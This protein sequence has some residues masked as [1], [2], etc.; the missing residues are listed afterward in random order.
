MKT[1]SNKQNISTVTATVT[2]ITFHNEESGFIVL[3]AKNK[4]EE[5]TVVGKVV[6][7]NIAEIIDCEG[8]WVKDKNY[9][10]QFHADTISVRPPTS[11]KGI[12]KYLSSGM[13]KGIGPGFAKRL[14][15]KFGDDVL[16]V[17]EKEPQRLFELVGIGKKRQQQI[18]SAWQEQKVI[19]N[20]MV[21]LQ[22]HG[23][24]C[25]RAFRIFR[26]YGNNAIDLIRKNPY[27]L[28]NDIAGIGF[29]IADNL[30]QSIGIATDS[31]LRVRAGI[32]HA[33]QQLSEQGGTCA[34]SLNLINTTKKLLNVS[35]EKV[36]EALQ[37]EVAEE[38]IIDITL[39]EEKMY[40]IG[41][42]FNA[43]KIIAT[44]LLR[45]NSHNALANCELDKNTLT[46]IQNYL[47]IEL[48]PSQIKASQTALANTVSIITGGPGVGKTTLVN[49][50]LT[51]LKRNTAKIMLA[52]P[53]GRAAKR[54]SQTT[55][56]S[57]KTIHR[58]LGFNAMEKA[59]LHNS[60]NPL[61]AE[62]VIVDEC[63]MIDTMLMASLVQAI[64]TGCKLILVGDIDQLPSVGAGAI[65]ADC[66]SSLQFSTITLTEIFR[67]AATSQIVTNAHLVNQGIMP[68]YMDKDP[69]SDFF[70][71]N[72]TEPEDICQK[73]LHMI[74]T[75][76]PQKFSLDSQKDIQVLAPTNR[77]TLGVIALN[78]QLQQA[79]NPNPNVMIEKFGR[80]FSTGDKVIQ[81]TNNYDKEVYNGDSGFILNIDTEQQ[82]LTVDYSNN[83][84]R[85]GF[86]ELDE[87]NLA[88]A[89]TIHK[90]QGSE[91]PAVVIPIAT[92]HYSL[93]QRN[94]IY[95]AITRGK[96]LVV[97]IGQKKA[98][99]MAIR[100]QEAKNRL[101]L[102]DKML[103]N[104]I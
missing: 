33:L 93:L 34:T 37:I 99:G 89:I 71:I 86:D 81:L 46:Q 12:E 27:R 23:I 50:I 35:S 44:N 41:Y 17:I 76:I 60:D 56:M 36:E 67:Q 58:M 31:I 104:I 102:L 9:G 40:A 91:Y 32:C 30:A 63:S 38:N 39:G 21:F 6:Q 78:Q 88:W 42:L 66:I 65:L 55:N 96:K 3:R 73:I 103:E 70:V 20:I 4:T 14:I 85:Y 11:T 51:I 64:P 87:I 69:N 101:T 22:S 83:I 100:N 77:G 74:T 92:Q 80:K 7:V 2:R 24:G 59:F 18:I 61:D 15:K 43:E 49:V 97:V 45:L 25:N 28:C 82:E 1:V 16:D 79:L 10:M 13:V 62:L 5:I 90:S 52:A 48:A 57:A 95:T 68:D 53:T 29:K 8:T 94:L 54:L 84:V 75:R 19:R 72:S 98:L 47:T 26:S